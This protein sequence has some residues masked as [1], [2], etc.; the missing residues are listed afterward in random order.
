VCDNEKDGHWV[1][2]QFYLEDGSVWGEYGQGAD[3]PCTYL[4]FDQP[5]VEF[6]IWEEDQP[7]SF[8]EWT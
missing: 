4:Y 3:G 7:R 6:E 1:Y 5:A 2:A 8:R